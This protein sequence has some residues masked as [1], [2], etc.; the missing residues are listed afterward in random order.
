MNAFARLTEIIQALNDRNVD[1][2][3]FGGQAVNLQGIP[4]FTEDIALFI[5]PTPENVERLRQALRRIWHDAAIDDI[6]SEDLCGEYAVVRYG[7]PDGFA[8]DLVSRIGDAFTLADIESEMMPLGDVRVRI[9]T[10]RMLYRMK[11]HTIRPIDHG[12]ALDLKVK[13]HLEDD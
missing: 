8:I 1:Y 2:V 3:L 5:S 7:T 12:D 6:R 4:R 10:P 13:F 11:R 9:A